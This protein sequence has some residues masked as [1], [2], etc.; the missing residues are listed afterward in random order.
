MLVGVRSTSAAILALVVVVGC[1]CG[2]GETGTPPVREPPRQQP[3]E[4]PPVDAWSATVDGIRIR[5]DPPAPSARAGETVMMALTVDNTSDRPRR[6]YMLG[7]EIFRA[8]LSD[9]RVLGSDGKPTGLSQPEPH[10]H[11]YLPDESDFPLIA[12]GTQAKFTQSLLLDPALPPGR[13]TV[14]WEYENE[15]TSMPGG[16]QTLDGITKPLFGG[17]PIPDIWVGEL[18]ARTTLDVTR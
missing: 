11:G 15:V 13:I 14:V 1:A 8:M 16:L 4:E 5:V 10:P 12:P 17:G 18:T 6:I 9:L 7:P 2:Q 3:H